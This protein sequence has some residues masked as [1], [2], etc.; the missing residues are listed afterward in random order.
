MAVQLPTRFQVPLPQDGVF[1]QAGVLVF[2]VHV[3]HLHVLD[4]LQL[5]MHAEGVGGV[6]RAYGALKVPARG[7]QLE[8]LLVRDVFVGEHQNHR[9]VAHV[10]ARSSTYFSFSSS[11]NC[12][13]ESVEPCS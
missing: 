4:F 1:M 13:G 10:L 9:I 12:F 11:R 7:E 5:T 3:P 6:D 8:V 2:L